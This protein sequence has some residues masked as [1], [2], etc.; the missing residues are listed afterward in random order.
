[1]ASSCSIGE[2]ELPGALEEDFFLSLDFLPFGSLD[3]PTLNLEVRGSMRWANPPPGLVAAVSGGLGPGDL[4][5]GGGELPG[6]EYPVLEALRSCSLRLS[7]RAPLPDMSLKSQKEPPL[8]SP[9]RLV[10]REN[11]RL[12][13]LSVPIITAGISG[14]RNLL[15]N[16]TSHEQSA[17]ARVSKQLASSSSFSFTFAN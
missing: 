16:A 14:P 11:F 12:F 13:L 8:P 2:D 6:L 4:P 7:L 9:R 15:S 3:F 10:G 17:V 1:M 5:G